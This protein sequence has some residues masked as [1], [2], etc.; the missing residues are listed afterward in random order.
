MHKL[1]PLLS[2]AIEQ[3]L[4]RSVAMFTWTV[5]DLNITI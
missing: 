1:K 3:L 4:Y 5:S 2:G